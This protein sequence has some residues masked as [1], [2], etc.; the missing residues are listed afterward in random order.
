M[1]PMSE[2]RIIKRYTNRKLYDTQDSQYVTLEQISEMIKT[3][4]DVVILD[5][6]SKED[7]TS[8]TLAQIIFEEE[9]KKNSFL[10]LQAMK[11]IIQSR[12][13]SI[14]QWM[15]QAQKKVQDILPKKEGEEESQVEVSSGEPAPDEE[16]GQVGQKSSALELKDWI[17][18]SQKAIEEWQHKV[19]HRI[20]NVVEGITPFAGLHKDVKILSERV[21]ELEEKLK[22]LNGSAPSDDNE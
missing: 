7:L 8:V 12:G 19:D 15:N 14:T 22:L 21:G 3:G 2:Q 13:E 4:D 18:N 20:R 1:N 5:N 16:P 10:P 9:K 11:N 6:K 17:A